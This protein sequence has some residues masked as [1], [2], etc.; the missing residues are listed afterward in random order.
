MERNRTPMVL[1]LV[2]SVA[3]IAA[4]CSEDAPSKTSSTNTTMGQK[5]DATTE[6]IASNT[7]KATANA[8]EAIDDAAITTKVKAAVL[9]EPGLKTLQIN[10]DTKDAVVTLAGTVDSRALKERATQIAQ[11]VGGVRSVIDN[12]VV[13]Q[14]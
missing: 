8:A 6:K 4:G 3:L 2:A 13:K 9:A 14:S 1:A 7:D 11:A 10:V 5:L 12:L